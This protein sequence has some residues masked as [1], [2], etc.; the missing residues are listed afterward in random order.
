MQRPFA[1][2]IEKI[3]IRKFLKM[4]S[5]VLLRSA[6]GRQSQMGFS[7]LELLIVIGILTL[8]ATIAAPR[9]MQFFSKAKSET[10]RI[11][12][13]NI[14]SAVELYY[15]DLGGYPAPEVGLSA[16]VEQPQDSP[17]WNGPYL[18]SARGLT[19]PWDRAYHYRFPGE[20]GDFDI[21]SFGRDGSPEG[22]GE[23]SDITSW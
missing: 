11:E 4:I 22:T 10:V 2:G 15:L 23:D 17:K 1:N 19:D 14:A 20:H 16:L 9:L 21:F 3:R 12:I 5:G 6:R 18:K 13:S 7:L 8:M